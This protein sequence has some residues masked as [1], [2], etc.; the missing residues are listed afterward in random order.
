MTYYRLPVLACVCA[1]VAASLAWGQEEGGTGPQ[2]PGGANVTSYQMKPVTADVENTDQIILE[3][4]GPDLC[5]SQS[6]EEL[7]DDPHA[8]AKPA[9]AAPEHVSDAQLP[10]DLS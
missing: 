2:A 3:T 6:V 10:P 1:L 5:A 8:L 4:F 7:D 9:D